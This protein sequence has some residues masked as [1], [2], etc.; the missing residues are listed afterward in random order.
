MSSGPPPSG[1]TTR[2]SDVTGA[3]AAGRLATPDQLIQASVS[4]LPFR[5]SHSLDGSREHRRVAGTTVWRL[6]IQGL[7][8]LCCPFFQLPMAIDLD[9]NKINNG[10]MKT[11]VDIPENEL[12]DAMRFTKAKTKRE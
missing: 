4:F 6:L 8:V 10:S 9:S 11:T 2:S 7:D 1:S 5:K 3:S 12:K